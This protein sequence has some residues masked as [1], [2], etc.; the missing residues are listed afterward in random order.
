MPTLLVSVAAK[1][2]HPLA[3]VAATHLA[4]LAPIALPDSTPPDS[5]P[6]ARALVRLVADYERRMR[7]EE[8]LLRVR[9]GLP[10]HHLPD[11]TLA[12][13]ERSAAE[14]RELLRSIDL[15]VPKELSPDEWT[16]SRML[17]WEQV[18]VVE[19]A[20]YFWLSFAA[21]T[22]YASPLSSVPRLLAAQS[23]ATAADRGR[24]LALVDE[25]AAMAD[26]IRGGLEARRLK[27]I[28]LPREELRLVIPFVRGFVHPPPQ[29]PYMASEAQLAALDVAARDGFVLALGA[30]IADRVNPA[31][32]RLAAYL[33]GPY[34]A[35]ARETVGVGNLPGGD[36]YYRAL[37]R[38]H[39]TMDVLPDAVHRIGLAEVARI[40]SAMALVRGE[41]GFA[42]TKAEF[43]ARLRQD[44]RFHAKTPEEFGERLMYHDARIRTRIADYFATLPR[45]QGDVRR[46][47]PRLEGAMTFGYYQEPTAQ[48]SMGHYFFNGSNLSQRSTLQAAALVY[49]ELIPGHHFQV[50]LQR[51]NATLPAFRRDGGHTAFTEG[52][53]DYA[54]ALAGEMGL[55]SDPYDRYGRLLMDMFISCRLV[56]DTGMNALGWSRAQAIAFMKENTLESDLQLDTETLRYAVDLP[57]QAL[58]YKMGAR[59]F[60]VL[61]EDARKRLGTKFDLR[62][63]HAFIL[64][65]GSMPM[66]VLRQRYEAWVAAG[67]VLP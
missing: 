11:V 21:I 14:A 55:Y 31:L 65:G 22:P 7:E 10:L 54:S 41:L 52:W 63:W 3:L 43:H 13:A 45:A 37:V 5:T 59:E 67:G 56:V 4:P 6:S 18:Q 1:A 39:T 51:E 47:D 24:Y 19:G 27:Q 23:L 62:R 25:V 61:R 50:A 15:L 44:P 42:G 64:E 17:R 32:E 58:A 12:G 28:T 9:T 53:G 49:H 57:G 60:L 8:P 26:T 16:T 29:S 20:R 30:R 34:R 66:T 48:D 36:A 38:Q 33:D 40:D 2:L 35:A 46:L